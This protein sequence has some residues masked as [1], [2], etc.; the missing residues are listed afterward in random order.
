MALSEFARKISKRA[1][2]DMGSIEA[3]ERAA[4]NDD[5]VKP[6]PIF[7]AQEA[8]LAGLKKEAK[9]DKEAKKKAKELEKKVKANAAVLQRLEKAVSELKLDPPLLHR[10]CQRQQAIV[11]AIRD[12]EVFHGEEMRPPA[13]QE[14]IKLATAELKAK[15]AAFEAEYKELGEQVSDLE[16]IVSEFQG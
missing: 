7:D 10:V 3:W 14:R 16:K 8:E 12:A 15:K 11:Q 13:S 4:S 9:Y 5:I 2:S 6:F 1:A